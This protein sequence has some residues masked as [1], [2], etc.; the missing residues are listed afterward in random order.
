MYEWLLL[1]HVLFAAVWLGGSIYLEG[2]MAAETGNSA[3][4]PGA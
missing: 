2:L 3:A 1:F 4:P